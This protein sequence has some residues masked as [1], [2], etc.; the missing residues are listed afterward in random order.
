MRTAGDDAGEILARLGV[1][2]RWH[3]ETRR[4]TGLAAIPL[5]AL[6]RPRIDVTVRISGFFRDAFPHLVRLLDDAVAAVASLD[7]GPDQNYVAAHARADAE[8]L[9]TELGAA[10]AWRQATARVFGSGPATYGAGLLQL[11]E[12]RD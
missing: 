8:R 7:E 11:L 1:R 4:I 5:E 3:A 10:P 12:T 9:A 6:G 2:P